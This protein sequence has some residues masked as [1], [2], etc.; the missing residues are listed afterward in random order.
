MEQNTWEMA[1]NELNHMFKV[2]DESCNLE[3]VEKM[4]NNLSLEAKR[5]LVHHYYVAEYVGLELESDDILVF[6]NS[7]VVKQ[8]LLDLVLCNNLSY[9]NAVK[10]GDG[11]YQFQQMVISKCKGIIDSWVDLNVGIDVKKSI[12]RYYKKKESGTLE[13]NAIGHLLRDFGCIANHYRKNPVF[14]KKGSL[15]TSEFDNLIHEVLVFIEG[16][17]KEEKNSLYR[18]LVIFLKDYESIRHVVSTTIVGALSILA[19]NGGEELVKDIFDN[20]VVRL[21]AR[22]QRN[23]AIMTLKEVV[24]NDDYVSSNIW[25]KQFIAKNVAKLKTYEECNDNF[26]TYIEN[27]N[28]LEIHVNSQELWVMLNMYWIGIEL[29][30]DKKEKLENFK[31]ILKNFKE[32]E[33]LSSS[34]WYKSQTPESYYYLINVGLI[35]QDYVME[36]IP[37]SNFIMNTKIHD[38][39]IY[40]E[41]PVGESFDDIKA[42]M[43]RMTAQPLFENK[44]VWERKRESVLIEY[45]MEKDLKEQELEGSLGQIIKKW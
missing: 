9:I 3:L 4:G 1:N 17:D 20:V 43:K 14:Y 12:E 32:W 8:E 5:C 11:E 2:I 23:E 13:E 19:E 30:E 16:L 40:L 41:I 28:K 18:Y 42:L 37:R 10:D 38:L 45:L 44:E 33:K 24:E 6:K 21:E 15:N 25:A 31:D 27:E 36:V 22:V 34:W 7:L 35:I 29:S 39:E 26:I